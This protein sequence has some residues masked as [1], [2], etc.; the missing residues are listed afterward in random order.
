ME[1]IYL[2]DWNS[3]KLGPTAYWPVTG[4]K[5]P[6]EGVVKG[7]KEACFISFI[8][9]LIGVVLKTGRGGWSWKGFGPCGFAGLAGKFKGKWKF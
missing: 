3:P 4:W 8:D 6:V 9:G 5:A 1:E 2:S 7:A